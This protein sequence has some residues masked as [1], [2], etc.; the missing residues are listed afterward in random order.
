M[1]HEVR[2]AVTMNTAAFWHVML[3]NLLENCWCF[4]GLYRHHLNMVAPGFYESP[5]IFYHTAWP[6][7]PQDCNI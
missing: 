2:V 6:R 7:N 3:C 4:R 5:R 1:R